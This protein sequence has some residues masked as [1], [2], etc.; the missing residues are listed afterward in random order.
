MTE[1]TTVRD[2]RRAPDRRKFVADLTKAMGRPNVAVAIRDEGRGEFAV[3]LQGHGLRALV[4]VE[5]A[6]LN[7]VPLIHWHG[8]EHQLRAVEG[9]WRETNI[10]RYHRRKA[11]SWP[12]SPNGLIEALLLGF[13]AALSGLAFIPGE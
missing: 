4:F 5:R 6:R 2:F 11:T 13:Y 1:H 8:A 7:E 10:N 3:A 9:A 12:M